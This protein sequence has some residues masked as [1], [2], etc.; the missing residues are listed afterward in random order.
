MSL[1]D[2]SGHVID[3]VYSPDSQFDIGSAIQLGYE[4]ELPD[5]TYK[6]GDT[7]TFHLPEQFVIYTDISSPLVTTDGTVGYFTVDRQGKVIMTF[8]PYVETH[9]NVSGKL[10][11]KTEF[12]KE[13][14][15]GSTEVIIAIPIKGGVQTVIVNVK[16]QSGTRP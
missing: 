1:T 5:N 13:I 7:F 8:N 12:T 11:I 4:W 14:V 9:S 3:A 6:S 2:E 16:P 15:K 10:Q